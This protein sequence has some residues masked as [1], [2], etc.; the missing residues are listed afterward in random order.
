MISKEEAEELREKI[1]E[2]IDKLPENQA[3]VLRERIKKASA[4]ELEELI[5][6]QIKGG[7]C[8]FCQII[9][10]KVETV[11]I[12]EDAD[13]LAVLDIYPANPGH[14]I[15]M[16]KAHF[17][18]IK[19]I[20]DNLLNKLFIFI[21]LIEPVILE[22]TKAQGI[23]II[24]AQGEAAGQTV[25]H[26]SITLIPRFENDFR[27]DWPRKRI[28]R[29]EIEKIGEEIRKRAEKVVREKLA[30][31]KEAQEK[32]VKAREEGEAEKIAR[33]MKRRIP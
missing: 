13:I 29:K 27:L 21:K 17:K 19:E 2:Q 22:T 33:H 10:G 6:Q 31:E 20:P 8:F 18:D 16:P 24:I 28:E 14:M 11:K 23:S 1:L 3:A 25:A 9:Q 12:Y 4:S 5:K 30:Q 26:F 32:E 7:E 15:V